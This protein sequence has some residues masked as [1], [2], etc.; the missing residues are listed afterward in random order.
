MLR[1][2]TTR[3]LAQI[4]NVSESTVKRWADSGELGCERTPGGHRRFSLRHIHEFQKS[5]GFEATGLLLAPE[6]ED[7]EVEESV[8]RKNFEKVREQILYLATANQRARIEELLERLYLRGIA[9]C[10]LYDDILVPCGLISQERVE[11]GEITIGQ[12]RLIN[13]NIE[14][15]MYTIFPKMTRRRS[16]GKM[17]LCANPDTK[18]GL[19]LN[20]ISRILES[21]GW[22]A[23]NLG[24]H[25]SFGVMAEMVKIEPVNL[26]CVTT[27]GYG[28]RPEDAPELARLSQVTQEYRIPVA[29]LGEGFSD[30][31][32]RLNVAESQFFQ[33]LRALR[34]F[35]AGLTRG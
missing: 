25:V 2:Y 6:W 29:L 24:N 26:V 19:T 31:S 34:N 23:L 1:T 17:G 8:N 22:E 27:N 30:P 4:W 11:R 3:E 13:N 21:E 9:V 10:E 20:A 12:G 5:R 33:S 15:A 16:N 32:F 18:A 7:P 28:V 35:I 14:E